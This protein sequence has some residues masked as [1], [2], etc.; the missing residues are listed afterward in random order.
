MPL[1][2]IPNIS[3]GEIIT[4]TYLQSIKIAADHR[5]AAHIFYAHRNGANLAPTSG[6]TK[7]VYS[8]LSFNEG[9]VFNTSTNRFTV[10]QEGYHI[11]HAQVRVAE[12]VAGFEYVTSIY[13]NGVEY[14]R[15]RNFNH[16]AN[17]YFET[18]DVTIIDY[19]IVGDYYEH[20]FYYSSPSTTVSGPTQ[21]TY[22]EGCRIGG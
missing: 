6:W 18:V 7:M 5:N 1:P 4:E 15:G 8:T 10:A 14:R 3:A 17:D 20:W 16:Y 19:A 11:L 21:I 13:K 9:L 2:T 22:F 12:A